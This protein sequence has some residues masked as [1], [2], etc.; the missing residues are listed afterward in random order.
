MVPPLEFGSMHAILFQMALIPLTMCRFSISTLTESIVDRFVPLNRALRIHIHLGYTM[1][2]ITFFSTLL[3][4]IFFGLQCSRGEE[5]MCDKFRSEIMITGYLI[6]GFMLIISGTAHFRCKIP[7][8]LFYAIHHLVF[9]LYAVTILHTFDMEQRKGIKERS[10]TFKWFSATLVFYLCDRAAMHLI[11]KYSARLLSSSTVV[12]SDGSRMIILKLQRPALF[13]FR[14]GQC[15]Y[16][17]LGEIDMHWHPFSIA[18]DP[19]SSHIEFYIEVFADK[20]WTG[21]LW[22]LLEENGKLDGATSLRQI[23]FEIMGPFGTSLAKTDDF[24]HALALGTG[25]GM[26]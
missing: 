9:I 13:R 8:E 26:Y 17:K 6:L 19:D 12:G 22:A 2:I 14:P 21:K 11:Q 23:R 1:I 16:L 3:F 20:S 24:S 15:A 5:V 25:T 18:S 10:Q 4:F 7:Y